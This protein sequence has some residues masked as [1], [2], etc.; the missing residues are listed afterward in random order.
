MSPLDGFLASSLLW[1]AALVLDLARRPRAARGCLVT[2]VILAAWA[3]AASLPHGTGDRIIAWI[4]PWPIGWR[5]DPAGLWLMLPAWLPAGFAV[6]LGGREGRRGF[7]SGAALALLGALGV[8]GLQ[9]G[10]GFLI[11]WEIMGFGGAMLLLSERQTR[12]S[13]R[14]TFFMLAL[15]E[16]GAIALLFAILLLGPSWQVATYGQEWARL[17]SGMGFFLALLWVAGCGAK[18]GLLPYYEW[19]PGAYSSGSGASGALL[20]GLLLNIAYFALG[21]ALLDWLGV[22]PWLA[23]LGI[24]LLALGIVTA[25]LTGLY[26]FQ[27]D[28]WPRLLAFSSAENA[29]IAVAALG[30]ALIFR[31]YGHNQLA[32][33]AWIV[34]LIQLMGHSQAK[35]ALFFSADAAHHLTGS[36][37]IRP[38]ALFRRAPWTLGVGALCA[39]MSLAALPPTIGF[40]SEWYLFQTLFHDFVISGAGARIALTLAGAGLALTAAIAL[41]TMVKLAGVGLLGLPELEKDQGLS[42][43]MQSLSWTVRIAILVTGLAV[44]VFAVS[45]VSWLPLMAS[46]ARPILGGKSITLVH[47]WLLIPLSP[48]FAFISPAKLVIVWPLLALIPFALLLSGMRHF[49]VRRTPLWCGGDES[50]AH[51]GATTAFAFSNAL[52]VFYSFVYRPRN[53][54]RRTFGDRPYFLKELSFDY[55]HAPVFGPLLFQPAT[56]SVRWLADRLRFLQNGRLSSY[57][58]YIGLILLTIFALVLLW[59]A[60]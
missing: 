48:S 14:D 38:D 22:T 35:G 58:A 24:V 27:Q 52:R 51:A 60:P 13:G 57:L 8:L 26:A 34:G 53:N 55:S 17:G 6:L 20:S 45:L 42:G 25:V 21:R 10:P 33:L 56:A 15:L 47:H 46:T 18:L 12:E 30:A 44:L 41:A 59:S 23:D 9:N 1:V 3:T 31:G 36:D 49:K 50:A 39:V 7:A 43:P 54:V 28:D 32:A 4:G 40:V 19:Y 11:A 5:A 37:Q 2:G 16:T 29:A